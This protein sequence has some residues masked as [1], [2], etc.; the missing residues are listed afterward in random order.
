LDATIDSI[1]RILRRKIN[2]FI[3]KAFL[4]SRCQ[5]RTILIRFVLILLGY[6]LNNHFYITISKNMKK[7]PIKPEFTFKIFEMLGGLWITG[8]I[9][10]AAEMNIADLLA[11]GP[12]TVSILRRKQ[13]PRKSHFTES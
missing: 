7:H 2:F 1:T 3:D 6:K 5:I 12:K 9:K 10:T 8:C 13:T 11:D 4:V